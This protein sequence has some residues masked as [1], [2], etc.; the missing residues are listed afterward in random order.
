MNNAIAVGKFEAIHL[1]HELLIESTVEYAGLKSLDSAIISFAPHPAKVLTGEEYKPLYTKREQA[2]L[3]AGY[4]LDHWFTCPFDKDF[5]NMLPIDFCH[6][7]KDKYSCNTLFVGVDF[8]F[9]RNREGT[10]EILETIGKE[11][12]MRIITVPNMGGKQKISTS[13]IREHLASGQIEEANAL[14]GRPFLIRGTVQKGRQLGRTIGFPTANVHPV[15]DKFLPPDGVYA[16]QITAL[17][18][19]RMGVVNIG[20]N[21]TITSDRHRKAEA[22]IFDFDADIYGEE[23]VIELFTFIRPERTF[24]GIDDLKKQIAA[25]AKAVLD[26]LSL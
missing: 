10:P 11:I 22:H 20:T 16:A 3:L 6:L 1:G 24:K 2:F 18:S 4:G 21:P 5:A 12:E 23:I 13:R 9:G 7:L 25:D 19:K 14:L 17:G 8:R 26:F 15:E